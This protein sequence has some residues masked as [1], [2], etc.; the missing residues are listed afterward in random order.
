MKRLIAPALAVAAAGAILAVP[1]FAKTRTVTIRD[2]SFTPKTMTV[3]KNTTVRWVWKGRAP[4][5]V[6]V[7]RGP[8]TFRSSTQTSGSFSKKLTKKGVYQL[9]CTIHPGMDETIRVR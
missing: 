8:V 4:H 2:N 9:H 3:K 7:R 5:N 1:A 6:T